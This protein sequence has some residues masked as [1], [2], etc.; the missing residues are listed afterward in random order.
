MPFIVNFLAGFIGKSYNIF[1]NNE[2]ECYIIGREEF[3]ELMVVMLRESGSYT[4]K[5]SGRFREHYLTSYIHALYA[6]VVSNT[7]LQFLKKHFLLLLK[8]F[9]KL[10]EGQLAEQNF[11]VVY[12]LDK[13][14]KFIK[15]SIYDGS[16]ML[17]KL[18]EEV[19]ETYQDELNSVELESQDISMR[20]KEFEKKHLPLKLLEFNTLAHNQ[21]MAS[22][23]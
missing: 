23:K 6:R 20:L 2:E 5:V 11:S 9:H 16:L 8:D 3:L 15:Y 17:E 10:V 21:N 19:Q 13:L 4:Q 7:T 14:A 18:K 12:E 22:L 1:T